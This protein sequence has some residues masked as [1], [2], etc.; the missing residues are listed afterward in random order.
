MWGWGVGGGW[1][2]EI[3]H[4]YRVGGKE[5]YADTIKGGVPPSIRNKEKGNHGGKDSWVWERVEKSE[6]DRVVLKQEFY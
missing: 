6:D 2:G 4:K 5:L 1:G 3:E